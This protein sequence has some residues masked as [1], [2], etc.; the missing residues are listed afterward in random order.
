MENFVAVPRREA[1]ALARGGENPVA[2]DDDR[3]RVAAERGADRARGA[4]LS[5]RRGEFA[6]SADLASRDCARRFVDAS[7]EGICGGEIDRDR[8]DVDG[9]AGEH[10]DHQCNGR[11]DPRGR[12]RLDRA[13]KAPIE[14]RTRSRGVDA[15]KRGADDRL[16]APD[17]A[18]RPDGRVEE[19]ESEAA[20]AASLA[21]IRN[22]R[23]HCCCAAERRR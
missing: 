14:M 1:A 2:G 19:R 21:L 15:R 11:S 5:D 9:I 23:R 20:H 18:A 13:G 17:Q 8:I 3:D 12:H 7:L 10:P 16:A 6:I 4:G 22:R